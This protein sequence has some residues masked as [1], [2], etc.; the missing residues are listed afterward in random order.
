MDK[1]TFLFGVGCQKGGTTWLHHYLSRNPAVQLAMPKELHIF[2]TMLRTDLFSHFYFR[3]KAEEHNWRRRLR[4]LVR[5]RPDVASPAERIAMMNDPQLYVSYFQKLG[6]GRLTGE[7]TPAYAVLGAD[8]FTYIRSLLEPHFNVKIV[9]LMRDPVE[10][11][12]SATR[13]LLRPDHNEVGQHMGWT[14]EEYFAR[15]FDKTRF[16]EQSLYHNT[17]LALEQAFEPEDIFYGFFE[18]MFTEEFTRQISDF[19]SIPW[20]EPDFEKVVNRTSKGKEFNPELAARARETYDPAYAFCAERFGEDRIA[21]IWP[22][23][24]R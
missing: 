6:K 7:I 9:F 2:D 11:T 3:A 20:H 14:E 16:L 18:E 19:L 4:R 22:R 15:Y 13:M 8:N 5:R 1:P 23:Y 21:K 24:R 12:R 17:I 10:R